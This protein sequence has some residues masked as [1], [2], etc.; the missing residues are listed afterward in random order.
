MGLFYF[1]WKWNLDCRMSGPPIV[2]I[3]FTSSAVAFLCPFCF[4][5]WRTE[6]NMVELSDAVNPRWCHLLSLRGRIFRRRRR[7]MRLGFMEAAGRLYRKTSGP[8][9]TLLMK[10]IDNKKDTAPHQYFREVLADE[11]DLS[12]EKLLLHIH[13]WS[14]CEL[15]ECRIG[16]R[17]HHAPY[18][19]SLRFSPACLE[20]LKA[21]CAIYGGY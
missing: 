19:Y 9:G 11:K 5:A 12:D 14:R 10:G 13:L 8:D 1:L 7:K 16:L 3:N 17:D 2:V 21:D 15:I 6:T 18:A 4:M 20:I